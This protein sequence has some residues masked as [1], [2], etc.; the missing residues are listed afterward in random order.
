MYVSSCK[1]VDR[2]IDIVKNEQVKARGWT[3]ARFS[4]TPLQTFF[5]NNY[6][7]FFIIISLSGF[8]GML[9]RKIFKSQNPK[10]NVISIVLSTKE[11]VFHSI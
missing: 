10:I 4:E 8:G 7:I 1:S 3:S 2:G 9:P 5:D 11:R 6:N